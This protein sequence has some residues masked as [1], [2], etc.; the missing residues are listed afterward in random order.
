[1][2]DKLDRWRVARQLLD[3]HGRDAEAQ[4]ER[5]RQH[6]LR[7]GVVEGQGFWVEVVAAIGQLRATAG[8]R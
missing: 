6:C 3:R 4:A 8:G 2:P 7:T 5:H 1:M